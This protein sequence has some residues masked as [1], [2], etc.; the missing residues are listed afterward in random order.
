MLKDLGTSEE[1]T[2]F[3]EKR[4][5]LLESYNRIINAV[6]E[7]LLNNEMSNA[8]ITSSSNNN[9]TVLT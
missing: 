6:N 1:E 4:Q 5:G 2:K 7:W 8:S 9:S 3:Q